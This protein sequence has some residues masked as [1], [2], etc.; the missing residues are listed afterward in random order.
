M[1]ATISSTALQTSESRMKYFCLF[2]FLE[3]KANKDNAGRQHMSH[4]R[5]ATRKRQEERHSAGGGTPC[6][7][8][9]TP[10]LGGGI[11]SVGGG[12]RHRL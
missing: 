1:D 10:S 9:G 8:G 12:G 2:L 7:G 3:L 6:P 11:P 4:D 5:L